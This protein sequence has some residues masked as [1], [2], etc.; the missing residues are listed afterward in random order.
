MSESVWWKRGIVYQI[1]PRS[2]QDSNGDGLGDLEGIRSRLDYLV[3]LGVDA[4]WLSPFYPSP[5]ADFG[6]DIADYCDVDPRFGSLAD[7]D[8]LLADAHRRS[9]KVVVDLVPNH[10]SERH[11]WFVESRASRT[12]RRRDWYLWRDA[13]PDGGPPNN[14]LSSFGGSA[15][16]LDPATGQYYYHAFLKEQP[17]LNWRNP[18]VRAAMHDVMRFWLRRGVDGFRVD[19]IYHLIK[20]DQFRD[21]PP[22]RF[23]TPVEQSSHAVVPVYT[24]DRPEVQQVVAEMRRVTD[25]FG[26]GDAQRVLIGEIYLPLHRL[27]AYYGRSE[28][29]MLEGVQLPFN[30]QLL[31]ARWEARA[32]D[33]IVT[34]YEAALPAGAWPNWVL[35]NHDKPRIASRV[36]TE[37]ARLAAVLLLTLRGTP[38]MYYGDEIGMRDVPIPVEEV[39]DP[40]EKNEPGKG[41]GRDP[42]RTPMQWDDSV[43]AGFTTGRPWLR[44]DDDYC[45]RNVSLLERDSRSILTLYKRLIALRRQLAALTEGAWDAIETSGEFFAFARVHRGQ[46]AVVVANFGAESAAIADG[47]LPR[48]ASV[49]LSTHLDREGPCERP[50]VLRPAEAVVAVAE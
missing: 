46:R 45:L 23:T 14:W 24:T 49:L 5:M 17:D 33:K 32:I 1:Y 13:G 42:E 22:N 31:S 26:R 35:G 8:V 11:P 10:T 38:T 34:E 25:E 15:W 9:L 2:F 48:R 28:T 27:V 44:L 36:G 37:Q 40:F 50:F 4:I 16:T 18:E 12:S 39:Q 43:N 20:D 41:V 47:V 19:V 21:N 3:R 7:F 29:G 6:Y 30:F